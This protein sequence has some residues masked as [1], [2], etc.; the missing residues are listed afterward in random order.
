MTPGTQHMTYSEITEA[1]EKGRS[2]AEQEIARDPEAKARV[3][4]AFGL[5]YC[6]RRYPLAYRKPDVAKPEVA[7]WR[8]PST[9]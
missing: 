2:L 7:E 5:E 4:A 6:K 3:E 1:E 9:R 8:N